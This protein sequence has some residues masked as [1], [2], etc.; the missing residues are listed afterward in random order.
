MSTSM[1]AYSL[2]HSIQLRN[3]LTPCSISPHTS[4]FGHRR[5]RKQSGEKG[6]EWRGRDFDDTSVTWFF[7]SI[8]SSPP[9]FPSRFLCPLYGPLLAI[10]YAGSSQCTAMVSTPR[11]VSNCQTWL[12][13][14]QRLTSICVT[15]PQI[16]TD[17]EVHPFM[18]ERV[19][20]HWRQPQRG[21]NACEWRDSPDVEARS[22]TYDSK[23]LFVPFRSNMFTQRLSSSRS[24]SIRWRSI[25]ENEHEVNCSPWKRTYN[26]FLLRRTRLRR[27]RSARQGEWVWTSRRTT[28]LPTLW[29]L[30]ERSGK[31]NG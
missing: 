5:R 4:G 23:F 12:T 16:H 31:T 9:L 25:E 19:V 11:C 21:E 1:D 6:W 29:L 20:C 14:E 8:P 18:D 17:A 7:M 27:R 26:P 3:H 28:L 13:N 30:V 22:A 15:L 2:I 24:C 10:L